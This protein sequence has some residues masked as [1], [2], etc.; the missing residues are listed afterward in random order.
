MNKEFKKVSFKDLSTA[1]KVTII[2]FVIAIIAIIT[3]IENWVLMIFI[4]SLH[5]LI[6]VVPA[7]GFWAIFWINAALSVIYKAI[8]NSYRL[9]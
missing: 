3:F 5:S 2:P 6:D 7:L 8:T 1:D 9:I 4:G